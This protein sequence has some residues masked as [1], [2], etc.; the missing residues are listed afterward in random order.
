MV[1]AIVDRSIVWIGR[2]ISFLAIF[3][4]GVIC[5]EVVAR[6]AFNAPTIWGHELTVY[7]CGAYYVLGGAYTLFHNEHIRVDVFYSYFS[8]RLKAVVEVVT[9]PFLFC[10]IGVILWIGIE[11]S[12]ESLMM[13]ETSGT[14]WSPPIYYV[15]LCIPLGALLLL[16]E[17][18][19]QLVRNVLI[20]FA[21]KS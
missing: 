16:V 15:K 11:Y 9:F 19:A 12:Y 7:L 18:V 2:I 8:P 20:A 6:Y 1:L 4:M 5:Y 21:K 10:F 13:G 17:G 3:A 14:A